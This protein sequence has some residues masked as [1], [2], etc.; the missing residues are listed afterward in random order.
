MR[1][2]FRDMGASVRARL[3]KIAKERNQPF[4]LSL[5][6]YVL[7]RLLFRLSTT[8]YPCSD[9]GLRLPRA[10]ELSIVSQTQLLTCF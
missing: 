3:L 9:L 4:D 7:Q 6:R 2:P 8:P 5:T 1:E 10:W